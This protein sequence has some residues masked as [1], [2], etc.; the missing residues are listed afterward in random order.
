VALLGGEITVRSE[1]GAG[2]CF[3]FDIPVEVTGA[4]EG[5]G[6][7]VTPRVVALAPG[8]PRYRVLVVDD[9][10]DSRS[11]LRQLLEQVGFAVLEAANGREALDMCAGQR[12]HLVLM[13]LRCR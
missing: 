4:S 8:Q 2:T 12:P 3:A 9:S 6:Q 5:A 13:D 1:V 7:P 11:V 10:S